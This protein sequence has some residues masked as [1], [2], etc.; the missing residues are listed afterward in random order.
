[1][2][3]TGLTYFFENCIF[4]RATIKISRIDEDEI[5]HGSFGKFCTNTMT[6]IG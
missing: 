6:V 5:K 4:S 1:M 3:R 2:Q